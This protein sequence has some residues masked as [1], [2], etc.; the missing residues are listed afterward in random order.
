MLDLLYNLK[1]KHAAMQREA[2]SV[3]KPS[4]IFFI[5]SHG[6]RRTP[7]KFSMLRMRRL[8]PFYKPK[9]LF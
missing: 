2:K 7:R 8:A 3:H 9:K 6:K 5:K 4:M 1:W